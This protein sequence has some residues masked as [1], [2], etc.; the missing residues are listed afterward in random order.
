VQALSARGVQYVE[1]RCMDIDPFNPLGISLEASRF[2][3]VFLHF[4]ALEESDITTGEEGDQNRANFMATVKQGRQPGL[5]LHNGERSVG[6]QQWGLELLERMAPVAALLDQQAGG[7]EHARSMAT[8][9]AKLNDADLTPSARVLREVQANGNSFPAFALRQSQLQADE[10][11]AR[12]LS[13]EQTADFVAMAQA[14]LDAQTSME[15]TQTGD[16]DTFVAAYRASTLG[17]IS[18]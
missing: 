4:L 6:L 12:P 9:R 17:N 7:D 3:D 18:V 1:V 14:S 2:L 10:L 15:R 5:Q 8:Q 13:A 11:M 16:F